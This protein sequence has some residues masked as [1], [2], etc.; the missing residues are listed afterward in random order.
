MNTGL[1]RSLGGCVGIIAA[2]FVIVG[3]FAIPPEVA[4]QD[5]RVTRGNQSIV[6]IS[7]K[8][9][10][11]P[12]SQCSNAS[13]TTAYFTDTHSV[14]A[15]YAENSYGLM[16]MSGIVTG[17]YVV[18]LD[19]NWTPASVANDA[20][21]AATAAGVSLTAYSRKVYIMP[22]EADPNPITSAWWGTYK[23]GSRVWIRD[24]VCSSRWLAAH[25]LGHSFGM[26]SATTTFKRVLEVLEGS[27]VDD[28]S[29][30]M[31]AWLDTWEDHSTWNYMTHFNAPEKIYM[32]WLPAS[33]VQ[34]VSANGSFQVASVETTPA[35]GQVQ[36]LKIKGA[37]GGTGYYYFSYRQAVGFS[38]VLRPQFVGAT[39]VTRWDG[40]GT[41][42]T[43]LYAILA[44]GQAFTDSSGLKV[45]QRSHDATHAYIMVSFDTIT[46]AAN[47]SGTASRD[48]VRV[49]GYFRCQLHRD[50][51]TSFAGS[52]SQGDA[53]AVRL[54]LRPPSNA[55]T[56][57]WR[58]RG[59][60]TGE[61]RDEPLFV[62]VRGA[63]GA[64]GTGTGRYEIA[65]VR[66]DT[67]RLEFL[68]APDQ[69]SP[70]NTADLA[71]LRQARAY[72]PDS[73][74][75]NRRDALRKGETYDTDPYYYTGC[76]K[77]AATR[78]L[79]CALHDASIAVMGE[80]YGGPAVDAV[81]NS[82]PRDED[83]D[84]MGMQV[85][86]KQRKTTFRDVQAVLDDAINHLAAQLHSK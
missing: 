45:T 49:T 78:T 83:G 26:A 8:T 10:T 2:A 82:I 42:P 14:S 84:P 27:F 81:L 11:G 20:D 38:S 36:A 1:D 85:F 22:K 71:I 77:Q 70:P 31:F 15:Y 6:I 56:G 9:A 19:S 59:T 52:C 51:D 13:L 75:W 60:R 58:G 63:S 28:Y 72:L 66:A 76:S 44:D 55:A 35:P 61:V 65:E 53:T 23:I 18:S 73:T 47:L 62:E 86:N 12:A 4:A 43:S 46:T 40:V 57:V 74:K 16:T 67:A 5:G 7:L 30:S 48:N 68:V 50:S 33:A 29:T 37:N 25:E 32:G 64:F 41:S 80:F 21:A 3:V 34:T 79:F 54:R 39:S 69:K 17:P 24:Y